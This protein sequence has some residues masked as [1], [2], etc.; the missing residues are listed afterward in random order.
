MGLTKPLRAA[1]QVGTLIVENGSGNTG[2]FHQRF[3]LLMDQFR[4]GLFQIRAWCIGSMS[5]GSKCS[6]AKQVPAGGQ[7]HCRMPNTT[8]HF[9]TPIC[10][11]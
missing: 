5:N 3:E 11:V 9:S 1:M 8:R 10:T 4:I 2:G 6:S 7:S